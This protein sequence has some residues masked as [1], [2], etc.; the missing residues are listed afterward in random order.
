MGLFD[1]TGDIAQFDWQRKI[2]RIDE[3]NQDNLPLETQASKKLADR[4]DEVDDQYEKFNGNKG[5]RTGNL[6]FDEPFI[7]KDIGNSDI[8][9]GV[10]DGLLRGGTI[11]NTLRG[12]TDTVRLAKFQLTGRGIVFNLKQFLLQ[13]KNARKETRI[14]NPLSL[15]S[16]ASPL[17]Q[18]PR[19]VGYP[20]FP[21]TPSGDG[22]TDLL[23]D[24]AGA[25]DSIETPKYDKER[26]ESEN[27]LLNLTTRNF[28]NDDN[29]GGNGFFTSILDTAETVFNDPINVV[30]STASKV[31]NQIPKS[32]DEIISLRK[33][34]IDKILET[35][36]G[37]QVNT[38]VVALQPRETGEIL[39]FA[40]AS[41]ETYNLGTGFVRAE[42]GLYSVG[43]SNQLQVPYGGKF[44]EIGFANTPTG[45]LPKDFVKFRIRDA[46]NGKWIIFPAHLGT[47]TDTVTPEW[48]TERY[49]GRPDSVHLYGG[50]ARSV[51]FD[52]K[53]AAFTKQEIP[54]IQ[55]KM[56]ALVG[57]AYPTF[58]K[59]LSNDKEVRPVAP[60][61]YLTIGDMFNNTPG[62]FNNITL[63]FEENSVWETD[64]GFQIPQYFSVSCEFVHVGRYLPQTL[65]KHYDIPFLKDSGVGEKQFGVFGD[66]NPRDGKTSRPDY[67]NASSADHWS[68]Q[69]I[70]E[71]S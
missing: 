43:V 49:I 18:I 14:Y 39:N 64:E 52:F 62:Y 5:L 6:G 50:A 11:F 59:I 23:R 25:L 28:E 31:Y 4:L 60:Y 27:R 56:N 71:N 17:I 12:V 29:A 37:T 16:A 53:V 51:S 33:K 68:K 57:L 41:A 1:K 30:K 8:T 19:H 58:K 2:G 42:G 48:T 45:K 61:I 35:G 44:A 7:I 66:K 55:E 67:V 54:L 13:S 32:K 22:F 34:T 20:S 70:R 10:D 3:T 24:A 15:G 26:A 21:D 63:T 46:V 40:T 65:G 69:V 47:I 36:E 9:A 38:E